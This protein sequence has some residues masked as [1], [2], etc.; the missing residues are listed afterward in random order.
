MPLTFPPLLAIAPVTENGGAE[1][2][3]EEAAVNCQLPEI[4]EVEELP[5]QAESA[6]DRNVTSP[7]WTAVLRFELTR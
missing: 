1:G 2:E 5:P 3:T 7:R 6:N 4:S